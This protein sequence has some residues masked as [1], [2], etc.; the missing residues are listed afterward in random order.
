MIPSIRKILT[1]SVAVL[2]L[3]SVGY[4]Q[5]AEGEKVFSTKCV[6]CHTIG[7]GKL[8]GPDLAG[9]T[10]R[11][12]NS[13]LKRQIKEPD[14]LIA[15]N[16]PIAKQLLAESNNVP[17]A[18]LGLNDNEVDQVIAYLASTEGALAAESPAAPQQPIAEVATSGSGGDAD[19]GQNLFVGLKSFSNGGPTCNSCHNVNNDAVMSGGA[20]AK[21]LSDAHSRLTEVGIK[22]FISGN[23]LPIPQ[24]NTA[25]TNRPLTDSE[26]SD[27]AAFL[28]R[29][30]AQ[31]ST[32]SNINYGRYLLI[33]GVPG[34]IVLLVFFGMVWLK[35]RKKPVNHKVFDRQ[36]YGA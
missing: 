1:S 26:V 34:A 3:S 33:I 22:A 21:D 9:V 6:A 12:E 13:W 27:I 17:M 10:Q 30:D 19:N 35:R 32:Q 8:V 28:A 11:R 5:S 16:D 20:L 15:E 4:G 31:R 7:K 25:Y 18:P 14:K 36:T 29:V 2:I 24:M 23:S